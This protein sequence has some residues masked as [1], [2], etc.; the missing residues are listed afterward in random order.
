MRLYGRGYFSEND[1][2]GVA[3][4][5]APRVRIL[6][7]VGVSENEVVVFLKGQRTIS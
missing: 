7:A 3:S 6:L 1:W 5:T 2:I 4:I